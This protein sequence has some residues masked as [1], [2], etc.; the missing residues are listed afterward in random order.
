MTFILIFFTHVKGDYFLQQT[1]S[2][3]FP[4]HP[5]FPETSQGGGFGEDR[6]GCN[7]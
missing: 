2:P 1:S 6:E 7:Q 4:V 3:V 5:Q